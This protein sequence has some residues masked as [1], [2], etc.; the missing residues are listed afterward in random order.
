MPALVHFGWNSE[1]FRQHVVQQEFVIQ[2]IR[3]RLHAIPTKAA[4]T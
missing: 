1:F 2:G 3:E 4:G